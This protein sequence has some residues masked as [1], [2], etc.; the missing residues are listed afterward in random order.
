MDTPRKTVIDLNALLY[1]KARTQ[2]SYGDKENNSNYA[3]SIE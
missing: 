2:F 1:N 3:N